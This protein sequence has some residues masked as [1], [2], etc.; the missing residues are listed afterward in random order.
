MEAEI[1]GELVALDVEA[2]TAFTLNEIAARVWR[3]LA[4]PKSFEQLRNEL[5]GDYDVTREQCTLELQALLDDLTNEGLIER[6]P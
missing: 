3:S 2:G 4:E 6:I 1:G 5:M